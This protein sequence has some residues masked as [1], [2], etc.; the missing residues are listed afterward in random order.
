MKFAAFLCVL[1]F[2]AADGGSIPVE[3]DSRRE[4]LLT[5]CLV[6]ILS[7]ALYKTDD[8][9]L[10]PECRNILAQGPGHSKDVK[11][12]QEPTQEELKKPRDESKVKDEELIDHLLKTADK[13]EELGDER[14]QEEFPSFMK[15]GIKGK[16]EGV[17]DERSQEEFPSFMKRRLKEKRE[18]MD[19]DRSQEEFPSFM[20]RRLKEKREGMDDD[21]SQEEFPSFMKRRL[22]EKREGMDDDRSQEEFPSF[23]KRRLKEKR[24]G[25]DDDRSQEEFPSFMKRRLKEKREGMDDDRSQEEF[26][27]FMKRRLKEKR[28]G[29]DDERSQEDFPSF[30]KRFNMHKREDSDDD[31]SQEEFPQKR[32]FSMIYKRDNPD[33]ERSQEEYPFYEYKRS[34]LLTSREKR[35]EL[36]YDRSQEAFPSY[37]I[38]R[39]Y[40]DGD[41]EDEG[42]EKR[43]WKPTHRYHH[44]KKYHKR[45]EN[46][47]IEE[48]DYDRSQEDFPSYVNK[49]NYMNGEEMDEESEER[50][51]R[52]WKPTHRYHHKKKHHKRSENGDIE[53][54]DYDR[55]QEDFPSYTKRT[56]EDGEE[57]DEESE[58]IEKRIWKPTHRYHHKKKHHKRSENGDIED[59]DYDRSQEDFPSKRSQGHS[60]QTEDLVNAQPEGSEEQDEDIAKRYW[61][62]T[63]RY[64]HKKHYRNKRGDSME[65]EDEGEASQEVEEELNKGQLNS[66]EAALRY[67]TNKKKELE[68]RL[69]NKG[70]GYEK[71]SPWI[72]RGYYHPAWYKKSLKV[73]ESTD[74]HP[75]HTLEELAK[76]L[77]YKRGLISQEESPEE[78]ISAPQQELKQLEE[79]ASV[80]QQMTETT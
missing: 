36:D 11:D 80:D 77:R 67:L 49:R 25:M 34:H 16:H 40:G 23:M 20:K 5:K 72:D 33:E 65:L 32:F 78:A 57:M 17:D 54:P 59:P 24:E 27:S 69:L 71:R 38:K 46:G 60:K 39:T 44:K 75:H 61:K 15:R 14:S 51:K 50:E 28:E 19:D 26:P 79:L 63:H 12:A 35:D 4:E 53:D 64:H 37:M 30:Y 31:R 6:E 42:M 41:E 9:P 43:I 62:P 21:R 1:V 76:T 8:T 66:A 13:R 70:D 10:H 47:D 74:Q 56:Y 52:I 29:M 3:Q 45:S 18:G 55:S 73:G 22:K 68:E 7:K 58:E 2:L 48:P